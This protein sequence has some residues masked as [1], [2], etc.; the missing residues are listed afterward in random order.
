MSRQA[1]NSSSSK[2]RTNW[3]LP[4][5]VSPGTWDY[6]QSTSIASDYDDYFR[7]HGMFELDRDI[8]DRHFQRDGCVI[9]LG[10][11]T[12]RALE[13]LIAKGLQGVAVDLSQEMLETVRSK[14]KLR[15]TT[16]AIRANL[17]DLDGFG[18]ETFDYAICLFSTLGMI[19]G[20]DQRSKFVEHVARM[21]KPGG[22]FVV[23]VHNYWVHVFD[24]E[25]PLWMLRNLFRSKIKRDVELGDRFFLY[26]GIPDMY[27]HSFGKREL[28]RLLTNNR[29]RTKAELEIVESI[30]LNPRQD[31]RLALPW[32]MEWLRASGWIVVAR[33]PQVP[34]A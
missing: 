13:P 29:S 10:C 9:D 19:R 24:P 11:G 20:S 27:L 30:P 17:V 16:T 7:G 4:D 32:F 2:T 31:G 12:A 28:R 1:S 3:Q 22:L 34:T 23:Q 25:G 21:L 15:S 8:I 33:K 14:P 5:G 18:D 26:R 6:A